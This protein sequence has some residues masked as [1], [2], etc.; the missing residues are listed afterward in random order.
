MKRI[1]LLLL[2]ACVCQQC[3]SWGFYGHRKINQM[4]IYL[5][6][7]QM[8]L[9]FKANA[10]FLEEHAVD[11]DKRRYAVTAEAPRHYIDL[12]RYGHF[13]FDSLPRK[14]N[15]AIKKYSPDTIQAHGIVP[16]WIQTMLTRLTTAFKEKKPGQDT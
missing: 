4:A 1:V 7:P 8:M 11:P 6:P 9:L 3:H 10:A 2:C 16:W 13:P 12:D 15:D 5:L 14:W